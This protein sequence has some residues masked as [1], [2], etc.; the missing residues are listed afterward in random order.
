MRILVYPL[1]FAATLAAA[2]VAGDPL[3]FNEKHRLA[4]YCSFVV[5]VHDSIYSPVNGGETYKAGDTCPECRGAGSVGDGTVM[6]KCIYSEGGLYCKGGKLAA[7]GSASDGSGDSDSFSPE[8]ESESESASFAD[9]FGN[10]NSFSSASESK[11]ESEK[12]CNCRKQCKGE[13]EGGCCEN[14]DCCKPEQK[15]LFDCLECKEKGFNESQIRALSEQLLRAL[16]ESRVQKSE[17]VACKPQKQQEPPE[18]QS[19]EPE[20]KPEPA[21]SG[22]S[23]LDLRQTEWNWQGRNNVP[24]SVMRKHLIEEHSI[25]PS[26]VD[27][28]SRAE[29]EALHSLLHNEEARRSAPKSVGSSGKTKSSGSSCP[30][31]NCPT[32]SSGSSSGS[33]YRLFGRRR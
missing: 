10:S 2:A 15:K 22:A 30:S 25:V 4:A 8:S 6:M 1:M 29:M 17:A 23:I 27:N 20:S 32:S 18:P 9:N 28:M 16:E 31:G 13:C 12:A 5:A 7:S 24:T 21:A 3:D 19:Q 11:S 26:S 33:R 14:C